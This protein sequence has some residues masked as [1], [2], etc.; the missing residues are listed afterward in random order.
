VDRPA[1][2]YLADKGYDKLMG[3]RP[4]ARVIDQEVKKPLSNEILFGELENGGGVRIGVETTTNDAGEDEKKLRFT[5]EKEPEKL[6]GDGG[7]SKRKQLPGASGP[8]ASGPGASGAGSKSDDR[9][10][11][12][13]IEVKDED[14]TPEPALES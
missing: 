11:A 10:E 13:E 2:E 3:A 5:Y 9:D 1:R 4:L 14:G 7:T 12:P 8:G 6:L